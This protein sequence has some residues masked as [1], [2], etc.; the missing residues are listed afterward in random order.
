M[1]AWRDAPHRTTHQRSERRGHSSPLAEHGVALALDALQLEVTES[2]HHPY[3]IQLWGAAIWAK[4]RTVQAKH[5]TRAQIAAVKPAVD[6]E[7]D[8]YYRLRYDEFEKANLHA[9]AAAL[10]AALA[11]YPSLI[12]AQ[13][14]AVLIR[15]QRTG[16]HPLADGLRQS[17]A[18]G[19]CESSLKA[20][21]HLSP[22]V[23]TVSFRMRVSALFRSRRASIVIHWRCGCSRW[24]IVFCGASVQM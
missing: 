11:R 17:S 8:A 13:L 3:F 19:A 23:P 10:G 15:A 21:T 1:V 24:R 16:R 2:R 14:N 4:A 20:K 22:G 9:V 5:I 7:R 12:N 6:A 18:A